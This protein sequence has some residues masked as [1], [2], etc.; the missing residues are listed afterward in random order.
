MRKKA[1]PNAP[2]NVIP[3]PPR[4]RRRSPGGKLPG[5]GGRSDR[6]CTLLGIVLHL[7]TFTPTRVH[8]APLPRTPAEDG[9]NPPQLHGR[10]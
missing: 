8:L 9:P 3:T 4:P 10:P 2:R 6:S 1:V 5:I 7:T